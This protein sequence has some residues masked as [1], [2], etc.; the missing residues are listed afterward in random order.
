MTIV[1]SKAFELTQE[2]AKRYF[3]LAPEAR[4]QPIIAYVVLI[5]HYYLQPDDATTLESNSSVFGAHQ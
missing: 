3:T 4:S 5:A 1:S 2:D